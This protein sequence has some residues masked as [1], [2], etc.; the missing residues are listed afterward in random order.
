MSVTAMS[1]DDFVFQGQVGAYPGGYRFLTN[2]GVQKT[3]DLAASEQVDDRLLKLADP[4]HFF[5]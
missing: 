1:T 4:H 5:I 2:I 3:W